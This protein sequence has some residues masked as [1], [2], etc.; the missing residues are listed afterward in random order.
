MI[1]HETSRLLLETWGLDDF[2]AFAPIARDRQ[3]MRFIANGE[4]WPDARIGWFMGRQ[5]VLQ[6]TL[7][8]CNW[9]LTDRSSGD[10]VGFCGLAPLSLVGEI[11][12]G[13]WLKPA[14][15]GKGLASE[16]ADRV[17]HAA[18]EQHA[19]HRIVAR[20][21][22]ANTRSIALM[23]RLGMTLDRNLDSGPAGEIVLY[24]L[25]APDRSD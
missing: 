16:A 22:R 19:I 2:E 5:S 25:D 21:Y 23:E 7:G 9:K 4:P 12:I 6:E 3:V 15:W 13:W 8:F 11:E 14:H 20:A 24:V 1:V 10:L 17:V 18:F